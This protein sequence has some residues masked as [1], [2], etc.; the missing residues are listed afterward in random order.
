MR[1]IQ[2]RHK[3]AKEYGLPLLSG[4]DDSEGSRVMIEDKLS[5]HVG[6]QHIWGLTHHPEV[7][8]AAQ[9]ALQ[10]FGTGCT[11]SRML[12]GTLNLHNHWKKSWP[13]SLGKK[14]Y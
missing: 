6:F 4:L 7:L 8:A 3:V 10:R 12:N 1:R 11:G 5:D 9:E 14:P 13:L 2:A